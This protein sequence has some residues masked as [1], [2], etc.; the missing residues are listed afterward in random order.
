[1]F[2]R[3]SWL[4]VKRFSTTAQKNEKISCK[5]LVV[6]GG[7]GGCSMAAKFSKKLGKN[8]VVIVEPAAMHYYQPLFTL[9][10]GGLKSLAQAGRPMASVLPR[11][12]RW[13]QDEVAEF[14]PAHNQIPGLLEG[15]SRPDSGVCSN[16]SPKYVDLTRKSLEAF[17]EG[18]VICTFPKPP[19]K[20]PGAPQKIAYLADDFLRKR[21]K[22]QSAEVMYNTALPMLFGVKK[23]A[24]A[25][26][27]V[28]RRKG[29]RVNVG[30]N[31]LEVKPDRRTAVFEDL[32]RPGTTEEVE[33]AVL[34]VTPP[35]GPVGALRGCAE[36]TDT[37]GFLDV[38]RETLQHARFPSV[39][40][41]GDCTNLACSKTA[42]AV[43][44]QSGVLRR[45]L[46]AAMGGSSVLPARYDG[47]ASCPLVTGANKCILAEF[48]Y[49]MRP[50]E[51]FP[52]NQAVERT[53][54]YL[55]KAH[56]LPHQ[57][58]LAMLSGYWEGP[59][60]IRKLLHLG[61]SR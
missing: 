40:G 49:D 18:N 24:D 45:N 6:G 7:S 25:L 30:R 60:T 58:W 43:A 48:D 29:V 61:L 9:V 17:I 33:Y 36:L 31:L 4:A 39:F 47:Y 34:H 11:E 42:A 3:N 56:V 1:M 32:T 22:R 20:C 50:L 26:W 54:M 16:Y 53:S 41:I 12:A 13:L 19:V 5:L 35:Q 28:A 10:G 57:Y 14:S 2:K 44:A 59:K 27:Q 37:A 23:Y 55:L 51:T 46:E 38:H 8:K 21:G 52:V 15:L